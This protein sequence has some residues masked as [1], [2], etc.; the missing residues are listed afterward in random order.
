MVN[1]TTNIEPVDVQPSRS[2]Q[3]NPNRAEAPSILRTFRYLLTLAFVGCLVLPGLAYITSPTESGV[4]SPAGETFLK[5]AAYIGISLAALIGFRLLALRL[6]RYLLRESQNQAAF[7]EDI[8]YR[9]LPLAIVGSAA[10]SLF[11]EL[12]VIRWQGTIFEFFA[13]YKNY[14][15]L[16]CFAGLGLGYALSRN[17]EG[18]PLSLT[19]CLLAW[20][21][22]LLMFLRFGLPR[23]SVSLATSPFLEQLSM[24]LQTS[25]SNQSRA[26]YLLL[27]VVFL[28]TALAFIPLGQVCGKLME[29][30]S[31]LSAYGL[32]LGGSL[33]GV[34][35]MFLASWLWTPPVVWFG[36]CF[37]SLLFFFV[38]TR[39]TLLVGWILLLP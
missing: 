31:Q 8:S 27:T 29:K 21:F 36:A 34:S 26:V 1:A 35:L 17:E 18:I 37:L 3:G 32:N 4:I 13:F 16:A 9:F 20:Q 33:L 15:L 39:T 7:L 19:L 12:A 2:G 11:L 30:T 24:G 14:G 5:V 10:L 38:R 28:L 25:T 22:G 23:P 6:E